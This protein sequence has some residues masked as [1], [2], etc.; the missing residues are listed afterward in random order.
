M[1]IRSFATSLLAAAYFAIVQHV[2]SVTPAAAAPSPDTAS[3]LH[4]LA[5]HL[6]PRAVYTNAS[7][8][9]Y[10]LALESSIRNLLFVTPA[11]PTP[12]AIVAARSASHVQSAVRCGVRHGVSVRP[13]SGGHDY[14]GLS[15]RALR[16]AGRPFAVVDLALLRAVSVDVWNETAWVGSGATLGE[17][18]YAI[19]NHTARLGFPGGLG[20][21][22]GVGGHLSGGGFGLLLRKHGLAADHVVDAVIVDAMGRLL[23]RAA[24]GEDLFWAIRGGGGGSFGVVLSWKLR[25]V[26]VPPV[27]T[28]FTIHRP[29][30]Q[31]ATALLTRWQH[32]APALP[33]DVFLRVVLQNQDAQFESLYLGAC[34]GLVATMARSFPELGMKAQDCIE[35]TWI[36][37]VLYFAFYG[38]GKPM[39]Q[40]L[41]R[42]TKP[43][44]YFKAKSD[45]VT[46]PMA[47]HVWERTWSWLL[48]DGAGLLI[49]DPYGGRMRSVAPSATPFPHRRELYNLQYYGYWFE[50]GTEA[51]EKHVGWIRGLHREM[52]PYV[53]KNPRGAYVN[54]RD[55]DLGVNDDDG[56]GGVTSYGKARVW[57]ETY[58]KANFE[59]LAAVKAKV[60][61]H[62]F[63]RH[64]QSIPPLVSTLRNL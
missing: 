59:R 58:F 18:Y 23:D 44:R 28:V 16:A 27:V 2:A 38:T 30:N 61:P 14:E 17:L 36:Q 53:S 4:C 3:F 55:L 46:E 33:R 51:K 47:S 26:R 60:D 49:L 37:A 12:I 24:M 10:T 29:R 6:P 43:D 56:H 5:V 13:R 50:N 7:R 39:E 63:F 21:T 32:V 31:S 25:L 9:L 41:D 57:G 45:Y 64:E 22:V 48:R 62:D 54:Y 1:A 40:L 35:M 8:S 42:G 11:T 20:P 19:A 15:Y 52:E 34:A